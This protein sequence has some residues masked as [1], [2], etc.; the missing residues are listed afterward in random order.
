MLKLCNISPVAHFEFHLQ[1]PAEKHYVIAY[2]VAVI[3]LTHAVQLKHGEHK[4]NLAYNMGG[5]KG[6]GQIRP[7]VL[8]T[9]IYEGVKLE[10]ERGG[11]EVWFEPALNTHTPFSPVSPQ[12]SGLSTFISTYCNWPL[13]TYKPF[14]KYG[15]QAIDWIKKF[16]PLIVGNSDITVCNNTC[17]HF[18]AYTYMLCYSYRA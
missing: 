6:G 10:R 7:C 9:W 18:N 1:P 12:I 13:V 15:L 2:V 17:T 11:V 5:R 14:C 16:V 3:C 8:R 4:R